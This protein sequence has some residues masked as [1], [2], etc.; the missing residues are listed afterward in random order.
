MVF[1]CWLSNEK[2][3]R[4][5][6][7]NKIIWK[8][9]VFISYLIFIVMGLNKQ[10]KFEVNFSLFFLSFYFSS[11]FSFACIF[12]QILWEPNIA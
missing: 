3:Q 2:S 6:N 11:L 5:S 4:K 10:N 12:P 7:I 8:L 9:I 1:L